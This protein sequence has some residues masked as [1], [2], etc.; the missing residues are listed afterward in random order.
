M[1][2]FPA[3]FYVSAG[4]V[5]EVTGAGDY[6]DAICAGLFRNSPAA[7]PMADPPAGDARYYLAR[8]TDG[9]C[10]SY[11]DSSLDADPRDLLDAAD[12]CP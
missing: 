11:G 6:E 7:D 4:L 1:M 12:P 9:N 10:P 2:D 5:S 8:G 3:P